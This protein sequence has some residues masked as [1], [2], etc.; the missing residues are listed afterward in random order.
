MASRNKMDKINVVFS[1]IVDSPAESK[2]GDGVG[3][4]KNI[5]QKTLFFYPSGS[6]SSTTSRSNNKKKGVHLEL[7]NEDGLLK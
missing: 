5:F 2:G 4:P 6:Q 3:R 1:Y 7:E